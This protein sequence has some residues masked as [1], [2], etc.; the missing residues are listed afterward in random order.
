MEDKEKYF[1]KKMIVYATAEWNEEKKKWIC[2]V[3]TTDIRN[4]NICMNR[5]SKNIEIFTCD[6][7]ILPY[8]ILE[9]NG[10]DSK[11]INEKLVERG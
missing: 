11:S 7:F 6:E 1:D 4:D 10:I 2:K 9:H 5:K 3:E 8:A